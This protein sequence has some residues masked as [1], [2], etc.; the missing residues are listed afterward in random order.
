MSLD[1]AG[2]KVAR[3]NDLAR[4]VKEHGDKGIAT[5]SLL[6]WAERRHGISESTVRGYLKILERNREIKEDH[7]RVIFLA[8]EYVETY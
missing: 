7:G 5:N 2:R 8:S 1:G 6:T 3:L 4:K